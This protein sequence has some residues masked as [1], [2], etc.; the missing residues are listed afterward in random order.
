MEH[1]LEQLRQETVHLM[2]QVEHTLTETGALR[3]QLQQNLYGL[4]VQQ[5]RLLVA[6][7]RTVFLK[8]AL[9]RFAGNG[10]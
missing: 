2:Q 8:E 9:E 4:G 7:A 3:R 10:L 6:L 1:N 5:E